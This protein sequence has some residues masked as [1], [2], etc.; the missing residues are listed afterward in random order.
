M[1]VLRRLAPAY[2]RARA[3]LR[4][5]D[6]ARRM[7]LPL[8]YGDQSEAAQGLARLMR[9][10]GEAM[11][12]AA[13]LLVPVPLHPARLRRRRYNQAA[14]LAIGLARL[15]GRPLALDALTRARPTRELEGLGMAERQAE[16]AGAIHAH[17]AARLAGKR[18]LLVDDVM[19][20]GAT[21]HQCALALRDAGAV[22]VE[23]LTVAR[24]A[25]PRLQ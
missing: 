6:T 24:V 20:I 21:A 17:P 1:R 19:T 12:Q 4:Y 2:D 5:D 11:L 25:D 15:T 13:D 23:V 9:R 7:I 14:Q 8:K 10:P 16:L 3:A 22:A 18:V